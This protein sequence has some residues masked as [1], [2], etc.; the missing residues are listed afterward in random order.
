MATL[1]LPK[2]QLRRC[3]A[4]APVRAS[5]FDDVD[6]IHASPE[7]Q[8][9]RAQILEFYDRSR[10]RGPAFVLPGGATVCQ[11][12]WRASLEVHLDGVLDQG[13]DA[14]KQFSFEGFLGFLQGKLDLEGTEEQKRQF[15]DIVASFEPPAEPLPVYVRPGLPRDLADV[16]HQPLQEVEVYRGLDDMVLPEE[17]VAEVTQDVPLSQ[18]PADEP[19]PKR[20]KEDEAP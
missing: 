12:T 4:T 7:A 16:A 13:L 20:A 14:L 18:D 3:V 8:R 9:L 6:D 5:F 2:P 17:P 11:D 1:A 15:A 10:F 19:A